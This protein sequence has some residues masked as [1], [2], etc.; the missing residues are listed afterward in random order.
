M[1]MIDVIY[2]DGQEVGFQIKDD[3]QNLIYEFD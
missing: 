3:P 1:N 2:E